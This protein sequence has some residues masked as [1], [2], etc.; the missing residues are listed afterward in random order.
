[1]KA[2]KPYRLF[3]SLL[4]L[5]LAFLIGYKG[6][7]VLFSGAIFSLAT[8][9][10][11]QGSLWG[12]LL[13]AG[14]SGYFQ[15]RTF[16]QKQ[17]EV[18]SEKQYQTIH[19]YRRVPELLVVA[20]ILALIGQKVIVL[21]EH[22]GEFLEA[23]VETFNN[24]GT[25]FYG[26]IIGGFTGI[27]LFC[28]KY[29][30]PI[31]H[32][33]DIA[34]LGGFFGYALGRLG[35]HLVGDGCWGIANLNPKPSFWFLPDWTWSTK[36]AHNIQQ[37]GVHIKDCVGEYCMQLSTPV[38]PTSFYEMCISLAFGLVI[39]FNR[40]KIKTPGIIFSLFLLQNGLTRFLMG[41]IRDSDLYNVMGFYFS[42]AQIVGAS[43]VCISI[44]FLLFLM[45][46]RHHQLATAI[47]PQ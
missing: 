22:F 23:P 5:A 28:R 17:Q 16:G 7:Y 37:E 21:V 38:Y 45:R 20:C 27:Y 11:P 40:N 9:T 34:S 12:G 19:P 47:T 4:E 25:A 39:W 24:T 15:W 26:G 41:F 30:V 43:L 18:S 29:K 44:T 42:Q 46:K 3:S 8:W 10:S 36:Y 6:I 32:V 35:C 31:V 2:A 33:L 14:I 13:L 1:Q